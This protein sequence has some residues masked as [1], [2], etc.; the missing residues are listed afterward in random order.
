VRPNQIL[1]GKAL[2]AIS[3]SQ[4]A[5]VVE[6]TVIFC[7]VAPRHKLKIVNALQSCGEVVAMIGDGVNDAPALKKANIGVSVGSATD[8][9]QET[10]SLILLDND[11]KTLVNTVEEGRIIFANIKKV[12]AYVLS[13]SFAEIFTIFGAMLMGWPAPLTVGQILWIHLICDGPSDIV[14]GFERGEEGVMEEPPK[15]L[16]ESILDDTGKVLILAISLISAASSLFLFWHFWRVYD[17]IASGSTIV[18]TVLAIQELVY[19]FSYRSLRRSIFRSGNFFSNKLLFATVALGF[20]QQFLALYIPFL[21]NV[22]GVVPL[23]VLDWA[24][25]L[26]VAFG[27]MGVVEVVKYVTNRYGK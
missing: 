13:N 7:R 18:F 1:E 10:A 14:L 26:I 6:N 5:E 23:H 15:S 19:I 12:V 9:A 11:F 16:K 4:L 3:E 24:L 27:M 20:T 25:V 2:E 17:D 22:L 8:V 21:N